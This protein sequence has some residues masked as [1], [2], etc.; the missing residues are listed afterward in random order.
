MLAAWS[1]SLSRR[2]SQ[3][4]FL[5]DALGAGVIVLAAL[6]RLRRDH[7]VWLWLL[8]AAGVLLAAGFVLVI[9]ALHWGVSPYSARR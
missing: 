6:A 1:F 3:I 7:P 5:L 2:L 4:G 9:L 8:L